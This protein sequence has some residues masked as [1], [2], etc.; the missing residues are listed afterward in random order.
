MNSIKL[1]EL[2]MIRE[3]AEVCNKLGFE[4]F[5]IDQESKRAV[6]KAAIM[7]TPHGGGF[8]MNLGISRVQLFLNRLKAVE[9]INPK[10][11]EVFY[12]NADKGYV[13]KIT[14]KNKRTSIDFS[15]A[16]PN[17]IK[18]YRT[19]KD[20]MFFQI[21]VTEELYR[22]LSSMRS[23]M[24]GE[25]TFHLTLDKGK[26]KAFSIDN[27]G[28]S[29]TT[30]ITEF[31]TKLPDCDKDAFAFSYSL[32]M[33]LPLLGENVGKNIQISKRGFWK[34]DGGG[35]TFYIVPGV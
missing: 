4:E 14:L 31:V 28:D 20:P 8:E 7:C 5:V 24:A 30:D 6:N 34:M 13:K 21:T 2:S 10:T 25:K 19:A 33:I 27:T 9:S 16:D 29:A 17:N 26:A 3:T 22:L 23:I 1:E 15:C 12:E 32:D 18:T 35:N 11:F